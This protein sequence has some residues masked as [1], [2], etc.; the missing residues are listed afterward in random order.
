MSASIEGNIAGSLARIQLEDSD[1][2]PCR[3]ASMLSISIKEQPETTDDNE[4]VKIFPNIQFKPITRH[5]WLKARELL[6]KIKDLEELV[7]SPFPVLGDSQRQ[8][9]LKEQLNNLTNLNQLMDEAESLIN[10]KCQ[11]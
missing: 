1:Q 11:T 4:M 2:R 9:Q 10:N 3:T 6:F 7:A 8:I 5:E